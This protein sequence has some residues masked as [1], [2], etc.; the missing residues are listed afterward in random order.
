MLHPVKFDSLK[1]N[2]CL[3][4][5]SI[6]PIVHSD[7]GFLCGR[8]AN[9][10][11]KFES[12][13]HI[14]IYETIAQS[15]HFPCIYDSFG[16]TEELVWKRIA[17]HESSCMYKPYDCPSTSSVKCTWK[18]PRG[19]LVEH[20]TEFHTELTINWMTPFELS[21]NHNGNTNKLMVFNDHLFIFQTLYDSV[22]G[23]CW[24]GL[25]DIRNNLELSSFSLNIR[26]QCP[27]NGNEICL[28]QKKIGDDKSWE[29]DLENMISVEI[30]H[31]KSVLNGDNVLC[32]LEPIE[33][34]EKISAPLKG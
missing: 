6:A 14:S 17:E 34:N 12:V 19:Q 33:N 7:E 5:L 3:L 13:I 11:A 4:Y 29:C 1:C 2:K 18:G 25:R 30:L 31:L 22:A 26:L 24:F 15:L 10:T 16:C 27:E 23:K 32:K 21:T 20:F 8:C 28:S 9:K